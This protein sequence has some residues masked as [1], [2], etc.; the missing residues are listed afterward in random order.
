VGEGQGVSGARAHS[1]GG[2][3]AQ[4]Q[5]RWVAQCGSRG[6][7]RVWRRARCGE[8]GRWA[9]SEKKEKKMGPTQ[10]N[11]ASFKLIKKFKLTGFD[12][13]KRGPS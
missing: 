8:N 12:S 4:E 10:R 3:R 11:N 9:G 13:I 6:A 2:G 7:A 5:R 1:V